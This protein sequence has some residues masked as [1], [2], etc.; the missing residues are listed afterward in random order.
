MVNIQTPKS[1]KVQDNYNEN[2]D[3]ILCTWI[4]FVKAYILKKDN[5]NPIFVN[6]HSWSRITQPQNELR[7]LFSSPIERADHSE[8]S[9]TIIPTTPIAVSL[10]RTDGMPTIFVF[11]QL[12]STVCELERE[13][14]IYVCAREMC[15]TPTFK[16]IVLFNYWC[17][18]SIILEF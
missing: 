5:H 2:E 10:L 8:G 6:K 3:Y 11:I 12:Y 16:Y 4:L 7:I 14:L 9:P 18:L 1:V 13:N 17:I 15:N